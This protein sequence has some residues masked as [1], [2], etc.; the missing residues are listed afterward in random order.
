MASSERI[1]LCGTESPAPARRIVALLES[2]IPGARL[3]PVPGAGHMLPLT[4]A[5]AVNR[6]MGAHLRRNR[7]RPA[8]AAA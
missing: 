8:R 6:A 1:A 4:H 2:A 5:A 3:S 7:A